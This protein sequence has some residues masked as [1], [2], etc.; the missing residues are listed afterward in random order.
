M[1]SVEMQDTTSRFADT[2]WSMPESGTRLAIMSDK[3]LHIPIEPRDAYKL[4]AQPQSAYMLQMLSANNRCKDSIVYRALLD[5]IQRKTSE[6]GAYT[7]V[8]LPATQ[9]I[10]DGGVGITKDKIITAKGIFRRNECDEENGEEL[11]IAY[12]ADMLIEIMKDTTLTCADFMAVKM[13]QEGALASKWLGFNWIPYEKLDNASGIATT[14]AWCKS[15][16]HF[17]TGIDGSSV[18]MGIRR[19]K[20][21]AIQLSLTATYGAG[22]ANEKK[23]V[24]ID[25]K[26]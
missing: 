26:I 13:L 25:F 2:V 5:P 11:Y 22:R 15:A 18:D 10:I 19:D 4:S 7:S 24:S 17:G 12:N 1:A 8:V 6:N 23:V 21:N 16:V 3:D 14:A 20:N 9:K